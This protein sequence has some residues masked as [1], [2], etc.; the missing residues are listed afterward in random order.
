L[1]KWLLPRLPQRKNL[2]ILVGGNSKNDMKDQMGDGLNTG[3]KSMNFLQ[4]LRNVLRDISGK[5]QQDDVNPVTT[6]DATTTPGVP[7]GS[8]WYMDIQSKMATAPVDIPA[9]IPVLPVS[10][11]MALQNFVGESPTSLYIYFL[12]RLKKAIKHDGEQ[13]TLFYIPL[14]NQLAVIERKEYEMMLNKIYDHFIKVEEYER[15][16]L[17]KHLLSKHAVNEVI[18]KSM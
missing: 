13:A 3:E 15:A 16:G 5:Y 6:T 14:L 10:S 12:L 7:D 9:N 18:R 1:Q 11:P 8:H 4:A 17:C 2:V